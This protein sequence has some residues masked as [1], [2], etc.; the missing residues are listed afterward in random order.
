MD[1]LKFKRVSLE[2]CTKFSM[3]LHYFVLYTSCTEVCTTEI[4]I[5]TERR[6]FKEKNKIGCSKRVLSIF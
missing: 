3:K 5:A 6:I 4:K 1:D 2:K